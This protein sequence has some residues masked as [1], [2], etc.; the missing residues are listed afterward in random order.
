MFNKERANL[1]SSLKQNHV[2]VLEEGAASALGGHMAETRDYKSDS[3]VGP[4][5]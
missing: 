5:G 1:I 4:T 3:V 2:K